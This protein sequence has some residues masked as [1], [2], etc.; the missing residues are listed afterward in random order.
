LYILKESKM[1]LINHEER[2]RSCRRRLRHEALVRANISLIDSSPGTEEGDT[3][4][5]FVGHTQ[6]IS[7]GGLALVIPSV[8]VD[9][10]FLDRGDRT[11]NVVLAL[12]ASPVE[13]QAAPVYLTPLDER[14]PRMG[15]LIGA[16]ITANDK[17]DRPSLSEYL[18]GV[19]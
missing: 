18:R 11:L 7:E 5:T 4:L 2:R 14:D 15:Y 1:T 9:E 12:P 16:R 3:L 10:R 8:R 19:S 13:I 6:N 17:G